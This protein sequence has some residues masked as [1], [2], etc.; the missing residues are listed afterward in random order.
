LC[1]IITFVLFSNRNLLSQTENVGIGTIT[2]DNSAV[3]HITFSNPANPKGLLIPKLTTIERNSITNPATGLLIFNTTTNAFEYNS[4]IPATPVWAAIFASGNLALANGS[5]YIGNVSGQAT[6]VAPTGD[7]LIANDGLTTI[8]P[9]AVTTGKILDGTILAADLADGA[10]T[11]TQILNGTIATIDLAD[12]SVTGAKIPTDA[13]NGT[14]LSL[15]GEAAGS[16]MYFNGTDW[17]NLGVGTN[18][19]QLKV[20]GTAPAWA[21]DN[22]LSTTLTN[23]SLFIGNVSNVATAVAPT[24]DVLIANDGLTTIQPNAVTTGK[25]L[26][27]TIL[28]ADLADGA[29]TTTQILD[30]TIATID[31]ADNSVTGAKIPTDAVNGTKLSLTGEAAGSMMYF[32]GTDWINLGVGTNNQQLKVSG[33]APAWATDNSLSTTLTNGSLFIGNGSNVATAVNMSGD[34]TITNTG[35]TIIAN[36]A[37]STLKINND[38][39]TTGKILDLTIVNADVSTTAELDVTKLGNG[40]N[41]QLI[42]TNGTNV[43]W[44]TP[45]FATTSSAVGGDLSGTIANAQIIADAVTSVELATNSVTT[46]KI[47]DANVTL[48]KLATGSVNSDKILDLTIVNADVSTTAELD[49]TKL[50]NGTNDQLIRTNGTNVEWFTPTYLETAA[51]LGGDLTGTI[52]AAEI[53]VGVVGA[54]E[55][56]TNSVTTLKI[57]DANVT[58]DK[59]ATGSVNSDKIVDGTIVNADVSTTAELDV[60][61]LGNGTNDQ[62]IRTNGTNVEWFTPTY[63]ETAAALGGDLSGTIAD[64]QIIANAV[65]S[66]ELAT[67]AVTTLKITDANVTLDKLATGSVNSDKIVDGTIVN[68]DISATAEIV[69]TKLGNGTNDQLIRT[70]G[71]NVECSLQHT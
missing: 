60:T 22:S 43:E 39:V 24:G 69:V 40:T 58:L 2:P 65:T 29:V 31:L 50:G 13:V 64:A 10:V 51:A 52:A 59:L 7:V 17:I 49:V 62:L 41:D 47:T 34:V 12:N 56:A 3:L 61:K 55:L 20:S 30:G 27:G 37:V 57:T 8:Q 4:G 45:T 46:L 9:N 54:T 67:N 15:T 36:D 25:I 70:N 19:Q 32:N 63:L 44:F 11:T 23:G 18:N 33:T 1:L 28:A 6:A 66:V 35:A 71:T 21:T 68:E 26:D 16:M 5:I 38:A 53:G 14:K 42:R 48:D